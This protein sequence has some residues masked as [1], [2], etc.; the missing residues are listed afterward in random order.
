MFN[1]DPA[2]YLP[3]RYPFLFLDRI[4]TREQ[5]GSAEA[6]ALVSADIPSCPPTILLEAMA[7][8]AGVAAAEREGEGGFLA[9]VEHAEFAAP[10]APGDRLHVSVRILKSFGRLH[11]VEGDVHVGDTLLA[12]A[13]LTLGVGSLGD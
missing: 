9:A 7:Q 2:A 6:T 1:A 4:T 10:P 3:H 11:L 8:L 5:G 12:T 13:K